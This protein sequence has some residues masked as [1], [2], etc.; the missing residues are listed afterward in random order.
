MYKGSLWLLALCAVGSARAGVPE[1]WVAFSSGHYGEARQIWSD[2]ARAGDPEAE[3]NLGLL[4]ELGRGVPRDLHE[5]RKHYEHA[6]EHGN[7]AAQVSLGRLYREARGV[8]FDPARAFALFE[9]AAEQGDAAGQYELGLAY[10]Q[11]LGVTADLAGAVGWL[12]QSASLHYPKAC[13]ALALLYVRGEGVAKNPVVALALLNSVDAGNPK[14]PVEMGQLRAELNNTLSES[15][16]TQ[17]AAT[18]RA[19]LSSS[20]FSHLLPH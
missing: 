5:A 8:A 7:A 18:T 9:S 10:A 2:A 13:Y 11:G 16:R 4:Y 12:T 15:E 14:A 19:L 20:N 17:A 3:Y 6:A 1:G